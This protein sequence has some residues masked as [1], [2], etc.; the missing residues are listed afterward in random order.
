MVSTMPAGGE[1]PTHDPSRPTPG[2]RGWA[3]SCRGVLKRRRT[4]CHIDVVPDFL[5]TCAPHRRAARKALEAF[6]LY[7]ERATEDVIARDVATLRF[8]LAFE[9]GW[10]G[11]AVP[12]ARPRRRGA[13]AQLPPCAPAGWRRGG[14]AGWTTTKR[15]AAQRMVADRIL[16]V[17]T[18]NEELAIQLAGR[19]EDWHRPLPAGWYAL[20]AAA[21]GA[22][23][24]YQ[25]RST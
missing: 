13:L 22:L 9:A 2:A 10:K 6:A 17:H 4:P 15:G 1:D 16:A 21:S 14:G 25:A 12:P 19:L 7:A 23:T 18:Y 5:T 11:G 20:D 24:G 8:M 3:T